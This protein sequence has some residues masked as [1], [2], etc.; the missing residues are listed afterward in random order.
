MYII[1]SFLEG[2]MPHMFPKEYRQFIEVLAFCKPIK[3]NPG[4]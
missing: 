2:T 3:D 4:A 1:E